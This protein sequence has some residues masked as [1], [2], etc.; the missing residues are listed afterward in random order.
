MSRDRDL[1][2]GAVEVLHSNSSEFGQSLQELTSHFSLTVVLPATKRKIPL[3]CLDTKTTT[4]TTKPLYV[5]SWYCYLWVTSSDHVTLLVSTA[6]FVRN[7]SQAPSGIHL[8]VY[9]G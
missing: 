5:S 9:A 2:V 6:M 4:T 3:A 7:I 1:V 8:N